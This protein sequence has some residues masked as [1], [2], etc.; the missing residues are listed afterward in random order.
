LFSNFYFFL[1][2]END[3]LENGMKCLARD[4]EPPIAL[5]ATQQFCMSLASQ[6]DQLPMKKRAITMGQLQV[7]V[8]SALPDE[9]V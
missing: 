9:T 6:L 3:I 4:D 7:L 2:V 5:N 8:A 1:C